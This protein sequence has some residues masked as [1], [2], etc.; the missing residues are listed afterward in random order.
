MLENRLIHKKQKCDIYILIL[1]LEME[2]K[3]LKEEF[4]HHQDKVDEYYA[5]VQEASRQHQDDQSECHAHSGYLCDCLPP[6]IINILINS[7]RIPLSHLY[8]ILMYL[9]YIFFRLSC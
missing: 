3:A 5:L 4:Q 9:S 6:L 7:T 1:S 8:R 2:L